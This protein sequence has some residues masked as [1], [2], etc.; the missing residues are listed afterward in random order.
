MAYAIFTARKLQLRS[1]LNQL[2]Y[3]LMMKT[4]QQQNLTDLAMGVQASNALDS[5]NKRMEISKKYSDI[6]K[7]NG[8]LS[9]TDSF[10]Y[11]EEIAKLTMVDK[12]SQ[13][14]FSSLSGAGNAIEME[15]QVLQT[16]IKETQS[17]LESVEKAEEDGIKSC[18]PKYG[19]G[20]G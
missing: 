16:H 1:R 19:L 9:D 17:E 3:Q 14:Q 15:M 18:A 5:Y 12:M 6:I 20:N 10:N 13:Q 11:D 7:A 8:A 2:N 4:Q